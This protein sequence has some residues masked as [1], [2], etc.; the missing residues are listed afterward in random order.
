MAI[1]LKPEE[2]LDDLQIRGYEIIQH[3][4]NRTH[5]IAGLRC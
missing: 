4:G 2:R 3:P 1:E 5:G